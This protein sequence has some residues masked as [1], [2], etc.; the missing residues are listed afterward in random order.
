[1]LTG[2]IGTVQANQAITTILGK[3]ANLSGRLLLFDGLNTSFEELKIRRNPN[4]PVCGER[5]SI[6]HL[7]DYDEFCGLRRAMGDEEE[8]PPLGLKASIERGEKHLLLDVREPY[9]H[10]LCHLDGAKLIPLGQLHAKMNELAKSD[11]IV[12]YCHTGVRSSLA[13][14]LLKDAGYANVRNLTGGIEAWAK[15]VDPKMPRY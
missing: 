5:P 2:I 14:R 6:T 10:Q 12:V 9:E 11:S 1:M 3:G 15:Q 4:C 8:I 7:V 13:A